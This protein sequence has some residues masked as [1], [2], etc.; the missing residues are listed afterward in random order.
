MG[1]P[2]WERLIGDTGENGLFNLLF[3]WRKEFFPLAEDS[4]N[5]LSGTGIQTEPARL[6]ASR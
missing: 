3:R 2:R 4:V 1:V 5:G 6:H